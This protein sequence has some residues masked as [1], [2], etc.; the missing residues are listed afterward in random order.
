[1]SLPTGRAQRRVSSWGL[2][3]NRDGTRRQ[4][5]T[6]GREGG[7]GITSIINGLLGGCG[8]HVAL[9]AGQTFYESG[10]SFPRQQKGRPQAALDTL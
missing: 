4:N 9:S 2:L 8:I 10:R 7:T 3:K 1:M 6:R 5:L